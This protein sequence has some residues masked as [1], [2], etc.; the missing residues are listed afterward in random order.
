[1]LKLP[2]GARVTLLLL[3]CGRA[4]GSQL[5]AEADLRAAREKN[6]RVVPGGAETSLKAPVLEMAIVLIPVADMRV[7]VRPKRLIDVTCHTLRVWVLTATS[8]E[9]V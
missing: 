2:H 9:W 1:M 7:H 4:Q 6:A 3:V 8:K 5:A